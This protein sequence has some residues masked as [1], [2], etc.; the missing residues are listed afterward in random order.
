MGDPQMKNIGQVQAGGKPAEDEIN[1]AYERA[2][3]GSQLSWSGIHTSQHV[4][5][6]YEIPYGVIN[7]HDYPECDGSTRNAMI[8]AEIKAPFK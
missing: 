3:P 7:F 8:Q 4:Y 6:N 5:K 2:Y 1:C